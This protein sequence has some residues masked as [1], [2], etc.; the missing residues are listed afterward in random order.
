MEILKQNKQSRPRNFISELCR[1]HH[2]SNP[3]T[4]EIIFSLLFI[5]IVY[6]LLDL[7]SREGKY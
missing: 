4:T 6:R 2:F 1:R 3:N 7:L 5:G